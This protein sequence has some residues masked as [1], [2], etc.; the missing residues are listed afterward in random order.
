MEVKEV[1]PA[2]DTPPTVPILVVILSISI[3][4][5]VPVFPAPVAWLSVN[6]ELLM[7]TEPVPVLSVKRSNPPPPAL[8]EAAVLW[9]KVVPVTVRVPVAPA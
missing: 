5:P 7:S 6:V 4:P 2:V 3:P 1:V 8:V 9:L